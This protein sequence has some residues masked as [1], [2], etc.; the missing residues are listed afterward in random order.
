MGSASDV[1]L[2]LVSGA[3]AATTDEYDCS[4]CA[5]LAFQ[6]KTWAAGNIAIQAQQSFDGT[7]FASIGAPITA[8]GQIISL[9]ITQ[10]PFGIIRFSETSSDTSATSTVRLVGF[11]MQKSA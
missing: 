5:Q 4:R 10:G 1:A 6:L 7:H 9:D 2:A 8:L 11:E 3:G